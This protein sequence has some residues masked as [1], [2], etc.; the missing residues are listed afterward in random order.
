MSREIVGKLDALDAFANGDLVYL[1]GI[2]TN[3]SI[4]W[5]NSFIPAFDNDADWT[6]IQ[7]QPS[8]I[9]GPALVPFVAIEEIHY[10]TPPSTIKVR[11]RDGTGAVVIKDVAIRTQLALS[12]TALLHK[13]NNTY[14]YKADDPR[15]IDAVAATDNETFQGE[16]LSERRKTVYT[17]VLGRITNDVD[18]CEFGRWPPCKGS[19][20]AVILT[21]K[22]ATAQD[23]GRAVEDCLKIGIITAA[24]TAIVAVIATG[25]A[26]LKSAIA[27]FK[28]VFI[29]CI[30]GKLSNIIEIEVEPKYRCKD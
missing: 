15:I 22:V 19:E 1:V 2:G 9:S 27:A 10:K 24:I 7:I 13:Y 17:R 20:T 28:A 5:T 14:I 6:F 18:C 29:P 23:I 21:I 12:D 8:G 30:E 16:L 4:G 25:G 3:T 26:A 11:Y